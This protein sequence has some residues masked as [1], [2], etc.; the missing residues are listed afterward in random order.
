M[1]IQEC[2]Q[3]PINHSAITVRQKLRTWTYISDVDHKVILE[4][5]RT[6]RQ[7]RTCS[8]ERIRSVL[9]QPAIRFPRLSAAT[10]W[11]TGSTEMWPFLSLEGKVKFNN[12]GVVNY[13]KGNT[14]GGGNILQTEYKATLQTYFGFFATWHGEG[15]WAADR[16]TDAVTD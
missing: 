13:A 6:S 8:R 1:W 12:T 3:K 14:A 11:N 5:Q 9:P 7:C 15:K 2:N 16:R 10:E 4:V